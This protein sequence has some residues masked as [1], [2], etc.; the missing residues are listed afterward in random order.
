VDTTVLIAD[1]DV[2]AQIIAET[3]LSLRGFRVRR[4]ADGAEA[5]D[6]VRQEEIAVVVL[7]LSLPGMNGFE[8]L[9]RPHGRLGPL[10]LASE[11][12]IL[13]VTSRQDPEVERVAL[14][15]GA[16]AFLRKPLAL[17]HFIRTVEQLVGSA[18]PQAA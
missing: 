13:A 18:T 1:D 6:I 2:N 11:P 17:P 15:L 12:R 7:D 10:P 3:L 4:A 16:S 8:L 5:C 9:R 14:R